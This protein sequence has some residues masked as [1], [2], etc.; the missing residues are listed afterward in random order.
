MLNPIHN[1]ELRLALGAFRTPVAGLYV[2]AD[3]PSQYSRREKLFL[4][5]AI[6]LAAHPSNPAHKVTLPPNYIDV[7]EQKT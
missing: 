1:L 5:Y 4:Q 7:Y 2:E 3:E 6:R